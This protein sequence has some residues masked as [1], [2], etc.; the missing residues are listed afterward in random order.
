MTV[1]LVA[2]ALAN[3]P[4][5]GGGVWERMSWAIG[6]LRLGFDVYFVEQ[7]DSAACT[8]ASGARAAFEDSVNLAWFRAMT[9][10]FAMDRRS[11][12]ICDD[13]ER[14]AGL[15]WPQLMEMAARAEL[16]VN[17][18]GHL[19]LRPIL[20]RVRRKAY[21][22][23][24]P[25]FTQ[26]WH[27]D[28]NNRFTV[29]GHDVYF[30]IGENI[31]A[32]GCAIPTGAIDWRPVRQPVVL[33]DWPMMTAP[34]PARRFTTVASWRGAYGPVVTGGRSFGVKAHEFRKFMPLPGLVNAAASRQASGTDAPA[35]FEIALAIHPA[36]ARDADALRAHGWR[37]TDPVAAAGDAQ[38]FRRYVQDST[39]EFSVA[40]GIYVDTN[41]GW[42]SDRTV[43][44]LASGRP[45][46]VQ[47]TGFSQRIAAGEGLVPF[48]TLGDAAEG[49]Q[50]ILRDYPAHAAAA[51]AVA[52]RY[53]DS[54][55]VLSQLVADVGLKL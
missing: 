18:S 9:R 37:L 43:R 12:L 16:L 1:V 44:Y 35:M 55:K 28:P 33:E 6:L 5:N 34:A 26:F 4:R 51:R 14:C 3:K 50:R 2:G 21:I 13:G 27:A 25:G 24:D 46:L 38:A 53:F 47:E 11:V 29:G 8:D 30:T 36:D 15:A 41:S 54:D 40:Q 22:D 49:A 31:G 10:R 45:A 7:I 52:E 19:T 48:T 32:P 42:F 23:V 20:E 39:A 17:L